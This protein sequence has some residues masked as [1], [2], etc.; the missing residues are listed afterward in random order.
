[1]VGLMKKKLDFITNSSSTAFMVKAKNTGSVLKKMWDIYIKDFNDSWTNPYEA[2]FNDQQ[3]KAGKWISE[4]YKT[5]NGN[6]II[7]WTCNYETLIFNNDKIKKGYIEVNTCTNINWYDSDLDMIFIAE[8]W[9]Y[10]DDFKLEEFQFLDLND[11]KV[12]PYKQF[13]EEQN[14]RIYEE[15]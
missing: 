7:P 15:E 9:D 1:M 6:V 13:T 14:A 5:F 11:M 12:K 8:D 3:V 4:N 10:G 2:T